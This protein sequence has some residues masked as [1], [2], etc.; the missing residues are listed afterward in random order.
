MAKVS[1][2]VN[3]IQMEKFMNASNGP[4]QRYLDRKA[5]EVES[6][7]KE[8][9]PAAAVGGGELRGSIETKKANL[10]GRQEPIN[11]SAAFNR[12]QKSI[13]RIVGAT[14][15][16]AEYVHQGTGPQHISLE[17][18]PDPRPGYWPRASD[19]LVRWAID[20]IPEA[21]RFD[22]FGNA[23]IYLIQRH[24]ETYGTPAVPFLLEALKIVFPQA[25]GRFHR[26]G[27]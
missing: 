19:D 25:H 21:V 6:R 23:N 7:A 22:R 4:V 17:G 10:L 12:P 2:K 11:K 5:R 3:P 16:H 24:I 26:I 1:V 8:L 20:N 15:E 13:G 18:N 27:S 9:A 14:A